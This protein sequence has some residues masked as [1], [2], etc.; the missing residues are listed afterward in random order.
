MIAIQRVAT[1][2]YIS[3]L[4]EKYDIT[5]WIIFLIKKMRLGKE[6]YLSVHSSWSS[7]FKFF[8]DPILL[9]L[10][11]IILYFLQC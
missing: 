2:I 1:L 4:L 7:A 6:T 11:N 8:M 5:N 3:L 9:N 10:Q